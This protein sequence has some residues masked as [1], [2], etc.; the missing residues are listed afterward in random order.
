MRFFAVSNLFE[1]V[2]IV[3]G[4]TPTEACQKWT[5]KMAENTFLKDGIPLIPLYKPGNYFSESLKKACQ[6]QFVATKDKTFKKKLKGMLT[7]ASVS[8]VTP[9]LEGLGKYGGCGLLSCAVS[10]TEEGAKAFLIGE[11]KQAQKTVK[12]ICKGNF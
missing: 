1:G 6:K 7:G 9:L 11:V 8:C 10:A 3:Y 5:D 4:K 12:E 2:E